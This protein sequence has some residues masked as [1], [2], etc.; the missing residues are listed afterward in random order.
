MY[1]ISEVKEKIA[2]G[3]KLL[4]AGDEE[5]LRQLPVGKWIGG[6]IP[7]FM[8]ETGG[9]VT[10]DKVYVTEM[11]EGVTEISI[12]TYN[13]ETLPD[14]YA[15]MAENGFSLIVIPASSQAH[16]EFALHAPRYKGFG[17]SPLIGWIAGVHLED[18]GR[19]TPKV[20][21]GR[22]QTV[23]ENGAV[24][25]HAALPPTQV[26]E[27]NYIN[28]F[29]QGDGDTITF[30]EDGFS[31]REAYIN[32]VEANFAEY[33]TRQSLD[34]RLP[35]VADYFGS[36]VNVSFQNVDTAKQEVQL[37]A[38]VFA[39][40]SYKHAKPLED[41]V[42]QFTSK[43]PLHLGEHPAFSCNCILNYMYSELEGK[44]TGEITG[45]TTFGEV[46]Y[47]LLNQTMAYLTISDLPAR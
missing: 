43:I 3:Q 1:D 8:T 45:P 27:I 9:L 18:I 33:V 26:A 37:Y 38:P 14:V 31:I 40:V 39:G 42:K 44:C 2:H 19:V 34:T 46:V 32:G 12:K 24:V 30:P 16:F 13:A 6:S 35:L 5:L 22:T 29:E 47:Q 15:D 28:I 20:F 7:Y 41:Y 36:M 23:L 25:I 11:P 10:R 4:L 17:H 21:D